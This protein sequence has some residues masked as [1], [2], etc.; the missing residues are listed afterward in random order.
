MKKIA[1]LGPSR[2][3]V[4]GVSTHL[5]ELFNSA[6]ASKW[7]LVH[8]QVGSE[9]RQESPLGK[10]GRLVRSFFQFFQFLRREKPAIVHINA[11]MDQK[12]YWRDLVYLLLARLLCKKIVYQVHG[13]ALPLEFFSGNRFLTG[14]L[15]WSL[16]RADVIVLLSEVAMRAYKDFLP[17]SRL[18]IV[19][20]AIDVA[21]LVDIPRGK[22]GGPLQLVCIGRLVAEKGIY[23]SIEAVKILNERGHKVMLTIAGNG[24]CQKDLEA[25]IDK[26]DLQES[27]R[28][29]GPV[30]GATKEALWAASDIFSFPTRHREGLPYALLEAMAAGV[31]PISTTVGGI[32]DVMQNGVHGFLVPPSNSP[33]L[34]DKIARLDKDRGLL[35][36]LGAAA[37]SRVISHYVLERLVADFD[38]IY[39]TLFRESKLGV[40]R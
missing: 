40:Q 15:R 16:R 37:R 23:E 26:L 8:F 9:G 30:F 3:A 31:V 6:L 14:F 24:P 13:G 36:K 5:N 29:I 12:S 7:E 33:V 25:L 20:N 21:G 2:D 4:S 38:L 39:S 18:E 11:S 22:T 19:P 17:E 35:L 1:L 10:I 27:V 28:F 32:P 34:A